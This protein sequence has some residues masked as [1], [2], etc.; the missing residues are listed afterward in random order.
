MQHKCRSI[1]IAVDN[2]A[3]D[4]RE[5]YNINCFLRTEIDKIEKVI[6]S[7]FETKVH[8]D[9]EK[10]NAWKSQFKNY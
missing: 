10:I 2:R 9:E 8:I 3:L 4:I 5:K 6:N 7:E 1:I